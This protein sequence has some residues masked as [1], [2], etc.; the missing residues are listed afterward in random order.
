MIYTLEEGVDREIKD[1]SLTVGLTVVPIL[2]LLL[3][4]VGLS[5]HHQSLRPTS[6]T[7]KP[8]SSASAPLITSTPVTPGSNTQASSSTDTSAAGSSASTS[9]S[10]GLT[11][12]SRPSTTPSNS[13]SSGL[14]GGR[15]SGGSSSGLLPLNLSLTVP[16]TG[17]SVD[18]KPA[19]DSTGTTV[20]VN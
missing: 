16:P 20:T 18:Q 6:G 9:T 11:T 19:V 12:A 3:T 4:A 13:S 1:R 17:L 10:A 14:Q 8:D 2:M 5:S 15:G 7:S